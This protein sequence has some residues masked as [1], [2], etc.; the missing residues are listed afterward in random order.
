LLE[1][2]VKLHQMYEN[3]V[4]MILSSVYQNATGVPTQTLRPYQSYPKWPRTILVYQTADWCTNK[5]T[6]NTLSVPTGVRK[7]CQSVPKCTKTH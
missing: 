2:C 3:P 6:T 7:V 4:G 1:K 5:T